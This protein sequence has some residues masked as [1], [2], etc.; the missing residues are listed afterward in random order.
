MMFFVGM[1]RSVGRSDDVGAMIEGNVG[2]RLSDVM[3]SFGHDDSIS[4]RI[5]LPDIVR[6][7][8]VG[9]I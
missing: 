5:S 6:C 4:L 7:H 1:L 3:R 2:W 9:G 8:D